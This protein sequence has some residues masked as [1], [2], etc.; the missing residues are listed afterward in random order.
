[1]SAKYGASQAFGVRYKMVSNLMSS[2]AAGPTLKK[3]LKTNK[4][5]KIMF[6]VNT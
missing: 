4:L 3:N 2:L 5:T 6:I 1:M